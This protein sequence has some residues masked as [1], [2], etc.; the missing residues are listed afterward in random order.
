MLRLLRTEQIIL[1]KTQI[2]LASIK[3]YF[4][5]DV[6]DCSCCNLLESFFSSQLSRE[7]AL[8]NVVLDL[9]K[10]KSNDLFIASSYLASLLQVGD[11]VPSHC[12][13]LD[14]FIK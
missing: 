11:P 1:I 5:P 6:S 10:V 14:K 3:E 8:A 7:N 9:W 13:F 4:T 2:S 12:V